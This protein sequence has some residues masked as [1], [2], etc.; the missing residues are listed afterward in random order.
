MPHTTPLIATIAIGLGLAFLLGLKMRLPPLV[1]YWVAGIIIG[2]FTPGFVA[3]QK[4]AP[5]L[6]EIGV[7]LLMF[8]VGLHFSLRDLLSGRAIAIPV[9]ILADTHDLCRHVQPKVSFRHRPIAH[10]SNRGAQVFSRD[11]NLRP[12]EGLP[13]ANLCSLPSRVALVTTTA[14][15]ARE[16]SAQSS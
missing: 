14:T 5:E 8:G 10:Q 2:P 4:L 11:L 7:I 9:A 16:R 13:C 3:D 12:N 15:R 6:G 1:G